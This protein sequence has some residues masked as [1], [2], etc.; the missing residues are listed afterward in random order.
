MFRSP[1]PTRFQIV[2]T[3]VLLLI[4][5]ALT[6]EGAEQRCTE[7][8]SKC[9][10]SEPLNFTSSSVVGVV[11][12]PDSSGAT[13]CN[14]GNAIDSSIAET[15]VPGS[16]VG[17]PSVNSV[18]RVSTV[19]GGNMID[20][21][22]SFTN[23]SYCIRNYFMHSPNFP[24]PDSTQRVK[25]P[26]NNKGG[27][28]PGFE[29]E[30]APGAGP[31]PGWAFEPQGNHESPFGP[32]ASNG[33]LEPVS[34]PLRLSSCKGRWCRLEICFDHNL[35]GDQRLQ[36]RARATRVDDGKV[37]LYQKATSVGSSS[38]AVSGDNSVPVHFF[39][40]GMPSG[41]YTYYSH[42]MVATTP[43]ADEN[44]WIG[45]AAEIEGATSGTGTPTSS[46]GGGTGTTTTS[47]GGGTGSTTSSTDG[48]TGTTSSGGSGTGTTTSSTTGGS[49]GTATGLPFSD[50][51]ESDLSR[52]PNSGLTTTTNRAYSGTHS[53]A[54]NAISGGN[55]S[56]WLLH[57]WGDT[58]VVSPGSVSCGQDCPGG[59]TPEFYVTFR[60]YLEAANS[61]ATAPYGGYELHRKIAIFGSF[62]DWDAT[63]GTNMQNSA[64]YFSLPLGNFGGGAGLDLAFNSWRRHDN[65]GKQIADVVDSGMAYD[66]IFPNR[67][68]VIGVHARL[69]TPGSSDG[70]MEIFIDGQRVINRTNMN[71]RGGYS[72]S[73]WNYMMFTDNGDGPSSGTVR[74]FWDDPS[75]QE[76]LPS[77][78][79]PRPAPPVLLD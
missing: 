56:S 65:S 42:V 6:A 47:T 58:N 51:F 15:T 72:D 50:D 77:A 33:S 16:S 4:G 43:V 40:Q 78:A 63:F 67:W 64:Y 71:F 26:R 53:V 7:L 74:F 52:W 22:R 73:T 35:T 70:L 61:L 1:T 68:Y 37:F 62:N 3:T 12:P 23:G 39:S 30:I 54:G 18:L 25:G 59:A 24:A 45:P 10:C 36:F 21:S 57:Y 27:S 17:L 28:H 19:N 2:L 49:G 20:S 69:N 29:S 14:G 41:H 5:T 66:V 13:Q 11:N 38:T 34:E 48:G 8:G 60:Y 31:D 79:A 55:D 76:T 46:S 9:A 75:I 44:F 32:I